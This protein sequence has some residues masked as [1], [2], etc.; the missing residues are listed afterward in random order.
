MHRV[1]DVR[2][3]ICAYLQG[4]IGNQLFILAA[5]WDQADRLGCPLYIDT[6][7]FL[8]DD[9]LERS[10]DTRRHFEL[11]AFDLPGVVIGSDSPWFRH[12]PR[13]PRLLRR[14]RRSALELTVY[15]QPGFGYDEAI[16]KIRPGTTLLGYFQSARYF[17]RV[18]ER[19][20]SMLEA[21]PVTNAEDS[22][23]RGILADPRVTIH[24]RRGDYLTGP[25]SAHHGIASANYAARA[26][27]L[28]ERLSP[29]S[30]FRVFSDSPEV[31]RQELG[32]SNEL[33][34]VDDPDRLSA[35]AT[36]KAMAGGAGFIMSNS[37]FSWWA[38]W[39]MRG[40]GTVVA[41]RPWQRSGESA[42]DLL[43]PDWLTL[44]AR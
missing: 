38:A 7:R 36:L 19:M 20:R 22:V 23:L 17:E 44:D 12:S 4:G 25:A 15:R 39:M 42:S 5:A 34:Y 26:R 21:A 24:L 43:L 28:F 11:S 35:M 31:A 14:Q 3:G 9:P 13:R 10:R 33:E 1:L 29:G 30:R 18:A 40:D 2:D 6:S 8:Q 41:P 27:R 37:S 32:E 16:E